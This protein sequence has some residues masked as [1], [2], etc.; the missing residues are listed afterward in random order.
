MHWILVKV[1]CIL[2]SKLPRELMDRWKRSVQ[3]I[4]RKYTSE[5]DLL[6]LL[7]LVEEEMVLMNDS[8][9]SREALHEYTK[10]PEKIPKRKLKQLKICFNKD[11]KKNDADNGSVQ[12]SS[13]KC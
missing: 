2:R 12:N 4:R 3:D 6:G 10:G 11:E 13:L 5:P 1:L 8:L 7:Q 9:F